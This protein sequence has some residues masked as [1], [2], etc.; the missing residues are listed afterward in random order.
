MPKFVWLDDSI[1]LKANLREVETRFVQ[2][3]RRKRAVVEH[4]ERGVVWRGGDVSLRPCARAGVAADTK[5]TARQIGAESELI[6]RSWAEVEARVVLLRFVG[7]RRSDDDFLNV[8][9]AI[10]TA[11]TEV[12]ERHILAQPTG[13]RSDVETASQ[14]P[15]TEYCRSR[16]RKTESGSRRCVAGYRRC[17]GSRT[18]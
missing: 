2:Q 4:R 12:S 11:T 13:Q 5:K 1:S 15:D 7:G 6:V 17:R 9:N 8:G 16:Q 14:Q 3:C 10:E 18:K